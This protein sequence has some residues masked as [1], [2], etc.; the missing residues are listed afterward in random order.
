M[1][2]ASDKVREIE[3]MV[4]LNNNDDDDADGLYWETVATDARQAPNTITSY[5]APHPNKIET[6]TTQ[7]DMYAFFEMCCT[8]SFSKQKN[9][10]QATICP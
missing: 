9:S 10:G 6:M 7:D 5:N 2:E 1:W 8:T 4:V 3:L